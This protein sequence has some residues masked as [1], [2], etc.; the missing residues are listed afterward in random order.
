MHKKFW[1]VYS[2]AGVH[3]MTETADLW[4]YSGVDKWC[5][6][7]ARSLLSLLVWD[8]TS[9][10]E[11]WG[12]HKHPRIL[13][14]CW[15]LVLPWEVFTSYLIQTTSFLP[16]TTDGTWQMII[17]EKW[18]IYWYHRCPWISSSDPNG[19]VIPP[20]LLL[21]PFPERCFQS[22]SSF[23]SGSSVAALYH[24]GLPFPVGR[25]L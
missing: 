17:F 16:G 21:S 8:T 1:F 24:W 14:H 5:P 4:N 25:R 10:G 2:G 9:K 19:R 23:W 12:I 6:K 7:E 22:V 18:S 13:I 11:T 15:F 3:D 20:D